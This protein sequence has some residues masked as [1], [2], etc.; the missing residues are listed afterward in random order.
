MNRSHHTVNRSTSDT[1]KNMKIFGRKWY[2]EII[3]IGH[4]LQ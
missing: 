1:Q 2:E 3:R 4:G